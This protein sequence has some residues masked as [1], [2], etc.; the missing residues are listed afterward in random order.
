[1]IDHSQLLKLGSSEN[2]S[3]GIQGVG[4]DFVKPW[5]ENYYIKCKILY[6]LN[7]LL[8]KLKMVMNKG[9]DELC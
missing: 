2:V 4:T 8:K 1:M 6:H 9:N 7:A 5:V 3:L